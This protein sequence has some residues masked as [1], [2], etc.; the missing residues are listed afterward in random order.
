MGI[1]SYSEQDYVL[2]PAYSVGF[3]NPADTQ[4]RE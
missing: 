3:D 4:L 1:W 2:F